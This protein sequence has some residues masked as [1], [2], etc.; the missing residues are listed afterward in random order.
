MKNETS[1]SFYSLFREIF[2]RFPRNRQKQF[3]GLFACMVLLSVVETITV[4]AIA[5]F[6]TAVSSP[7]GV[8]QSEKLTRA[9][10]IFGMEFLGT[11]QGLVISISLLVVFLM[12]LKNGLQ[13]LLLF[14]ATR[15]GAQVEAFFGDKLFKGFLEMPYE[16]H[17]SQNSADIVLAV[18]W[19]SY[20]GHGFTDNCF[21]IIGDTLLV[22]LM[23]STLFIVQPATSVLLLLIA[24]GTAYF[25]YTKM[26][27]LQKKMSERCMQFSRSLNRD[28]T[29][30]IH[31]IKDV[32]VSGHD[33]FAEDFEK[34]AYSFAISMGLRNLFSGLP[35]RFMEVIGFVMITSTVCLMLFFMD[36]STTKITATISLLVVAAWRILP[37]IT[38]ILSSFTG[39]RGLIPFLQT[40]IG[41]IKEIESNSNHQK[42][43]GTL[44]EVDFPFTNEIRFEKVSFNYKAREAYV[45]E[46]ISFLI[47]KGQTTGFIGCSGAGKSTLVDILIGLLVP[48][49]GKVFIDGRELDSMGRLAWMKTVG[50]VP[51]SPY[52]YDGTLA[53]NIAFGLSESEIDRALV[54]DCCHK[55]SMH[56]ILDSLPEGIDTPIG[57]R[58]VR[59]S[60]GQQQ[61]VVIARALYP[62]PEVMIFDEATSSLDAKS[63]KAIQNTI[64]GLR[65]SQTLIIIAHRLATVKDCDFL[66]WIENGK[67]KMNGTPTQV[68]NE[69]E[70]ALQVEVA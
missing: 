15:F 57:E 36:S 53:G 24:G 64:Y 47:K 55:A 56:D 1:Q 32:K 17:L 70:K 31:G 45:L 40:E 60:G 42:I 48:S 66:V 21:K 16:W 44:A 5:F 12:V 62:K 37:A 65:G 9:R 59:L 22:L 58:G 30:G 18:D 54:L 46:D 63:E 2:G 29:K 3:F 52:I 27:Y 11:I 25:V 67:I 34:D 49:A 23:V 38:R 39:F 20:I 68:L 6:M 43:A 35:V 26:H 10:E 50:Y 51:Q 61:R 28:V 69:Y 4:G 8:M 7:E 19:R 14:W 33:S 41:Y 13:S